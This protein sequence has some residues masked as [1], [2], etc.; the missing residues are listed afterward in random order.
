MPYSGWLELRVSRD[1]QVVSWPQ[2]RG[3]LLQWKMSG[4]SGCT[5]VLCP[6]LG[7]RQDE[8][9]YSNKIQ[10][11]RRGCLFTSVRSLLNTRRLLRDGSKMHSCYPKLIPAGNWSTR[12]SLWRALLTDLPPH[13]STASRLT[14]CPFRV[15]TTRRPEHSATSPPSK[16]CTVSMWVTCWHSA[17]P[18]WSVVRWKSITSSATVWKCKLTSQTAWHLIA[19]PARTCATTSPC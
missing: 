1:W 5:W 3:T 10:R 11:F 17:P 14:A 9:K 8:T 12:T 6:N 15:G 7:S 18:G 16:R 13:S 4:S 2:T 19:L